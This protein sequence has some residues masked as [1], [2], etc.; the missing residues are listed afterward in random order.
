MRGLGPD[1]VRVPR[2]P[3]LHDRQLEPHAPGCR[4]GRAH[5][6]GNFDDLPGWLDMEK[7]GGHQSTRRTAAMASL[8]VSSCLPYQ[9][10]AFGRS[11]VVVSRARLS[12][13]TVISENS[14]SSA[15]A[16][17]GEIGPLTLGLDPKVSSHLLEGGFHPPARDEPAED[18]RRGRIQVGAEERRRLVLAGWIAY[19]HPA[20][21][22]RRDAGMVPDRSVGGGEQLAWLG[23]VRV[24]PL[25]DDHGR[26]DGLPAGQHGTQCRQ[27][28]PLSA[29]DARA[30]RSGAAA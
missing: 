1:G 30:E 26:L 5:A 19:Q 3:V 18:H 10:A 8:N 14:P 27:A 21:R 4:Q 12:A 20:D 28:P 6:R 13:H 16:E 11:A 17:V 9:A 7:F 15:G 23:V 29:G 22:H 25:S 24:V 2:R